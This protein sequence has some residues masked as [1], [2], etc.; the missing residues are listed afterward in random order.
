MPAKYDKE[1]FEY[2]EMRESFF[3]RNICMYMY[4]YYQGPRAF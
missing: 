2:M 1:R 4:N 3:F